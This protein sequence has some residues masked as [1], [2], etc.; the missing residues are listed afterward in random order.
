MGEQPEQEPREFPKNLGEPMRPVEDTTDAELHPRFWEAQRAAARRGSLAWGFAAFFIGYGG[1]YLTV[2]ILNAVRPSRAGGFDP[3]T[4]PNTGPLLLLA[5]APNILLGLVP[6]VFSWWRGRG[7][8][9]DFGILPK[10]RDFKVG[11]ACGG[12]ALLGSWALTL[13]IIAIAGPPPETDLARLMQGE[14]T[15]WLFLFALFAFLGAPLTEELLM[16]G[17]LWGALEHYRIPRY[18]ILVLTALIFALIHQEVWRT[19]VLFFGGLAIGAARMITGRVAASMIAHATNN[20]LPALL[21][22]AIA[23]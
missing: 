6:A 21:L 20:F 23:R 5:F 17:A 4:P 9:S 10:R 13:V 7:L 8:R 16:R 1:Y 11:L 15:V 18:A 3:T 2:L 14:R 22:F 19:P 12:I